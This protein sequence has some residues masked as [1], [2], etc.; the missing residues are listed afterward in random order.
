MSFLQLKIF[1][2]LK[3]Q[4]TYYTSLGDQR[5]QLVIYNQG[6]TKPQTIQADYTECAYHNILFLYPTVVALFCCCNKILQS[7]LKQVSMLSYSSGGQMSKRGWRAT[8][9][10]KTPRERIMALGPLAS[11]V[12]SSNLC[13]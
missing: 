2:H 9:L 6:D 5:A 11:S 8:L 3:S 4:I 13:P 1:S 7:H 12:T 10:L